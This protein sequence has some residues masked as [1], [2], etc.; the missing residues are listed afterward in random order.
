[1][2][3][4]NLCRKSP[5]RR[6]TAEPGRNLRR[7][8]NWGP[9]GQAMKLFQSCLLVAM[10]AGLAAFTSAQADDSNISGVGGAVTAMTPSRFVR[11]VAETVVCDAPTGAVDATFVFHNDGPATDVHMGFPEEGGGVTSHDGYADLRSFQSYVDGQPVKAVRSPG[12]VNPASGDGEDFGGWWVKTVHFDPDQTRIV[13]DR[14]VGGIGDDSLGDNYLEYILSTGA[15]WKDPIGDVTVICRMHGRVAGNFDNAAPRGYRHDG[16]MLVWHWH[17][18][19][20]TADDYISVYWFGTL[21]IF[22]GGM[23]WPVGSAWDYKHWGADLPLV[24]DGHLYVSATAPANWLRLSRRQEAPGVVVLRRDPVYH[25]G[26]Y[27]PP[28]GGPYSVRVRAG[29]RMLQTYKG[30]ITLSGAAVEKGGDV[31]AP[32]TSIVEG[33]SLDLDEN[34]PNGGLVV[35]YPQSDYKQYD[36]QYG[37]SPEP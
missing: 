6:N 31:V 7:A 21:L 2:A 4:S 29:S 19:K 1:M 30:S 16:N 32:L 10:I 14:Y 20:P 27:P 26:K 11:M 5:L 34:H 25:G 33:V 35:S 13:V 22:D 18:L 3:Q 28:A 37:R 8:Q 36:K 23:I 24:R 15:A 9:G 17:N 12:K